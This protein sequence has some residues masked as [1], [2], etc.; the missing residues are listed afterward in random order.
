M[1]K[2]AA[3][4]CFTFAAL[5]LVTGC[6]L[7]TGQVL[8][9]EA[10]NL[11]AGVVTGVVKGSIE[12]ST[13][14]STEGHV[15]SSSGLTGGDLPPCPGSYGESA[16]S[17]C[18]GTYTHANGNKYLGEYR[19]D[20]RHGQ[21]SFTYASGGKYVGEWRA[22]LPNGQGAYLYANGKVTEGIW[23]NGCLGEFCV[24]PSSK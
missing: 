16:W 21:G 15:E 1:K 10:A 7:S 23:E 3:L 5:L 18:Y 22:G 12:G 9:L 20:K 6:N 4:L 8:V 13:E 14:G 17:N 24:S 2:L 11:I 19:N